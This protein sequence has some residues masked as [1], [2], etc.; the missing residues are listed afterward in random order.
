MCSGL[1]WYALLSTYLVLLVFVWDLE[2]TSLRD[3][4]S[5]RRSEMKERLQL[6]RD[7]DLRVD[8]SH[9][10]LKKQMDQ[11]K[12]KFFQYIFQEA[13]NPLTQLMHGVDIMQ[14]GCL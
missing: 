2:R 13:Q 11:E 3:F 5:M 8:E 10:Q 14:V 7:C 9:A 4:V 1:D 12:R 6:A